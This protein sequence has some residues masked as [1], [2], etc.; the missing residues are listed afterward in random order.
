MTYP[1]IETK[2]DYDE[3]VS[4]C[5]AFFKANGIEGGFSVEEDSEPY[6]SWTRCDCCDRNLGGDRYDVTSYSQRDKEVYEFS[7]CTDCYYYA[8]YGRLDDQT[9]LDIGEDI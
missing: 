9:M 6:F 1:H 5:E 4:D 7:V 3:Y 8:E 2:A